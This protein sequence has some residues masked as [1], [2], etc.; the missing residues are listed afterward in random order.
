MNLNMMDLDSGIARAIFSGMLKTNNCVIVE[1]ITWPN[2]CP[3]MN[4]RTHLG[5]TIED[6]RTYGINLVIYKYYNN[7]MIRSTTGSVRNMYDGFMNCLKLPNKKMCDICNN[8]NTIF[9]QCVKCKH[10]LCF[11]CFNK[12]NKDYAN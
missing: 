8:K 2:C 3:L 9:R 12:H 5:F 1:T 6:I 11:E 7:T 4:L 10:K